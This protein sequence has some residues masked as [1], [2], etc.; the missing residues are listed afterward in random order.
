MVTTPIKISLTERY[1]GAM[2]GLACGD[3]VGCT[4]EFY[5]R[6]KFKP[7]T[8]MTGGGKFRLNPG[9]W[10]DDTSMAICLASSLIECQGHDPVD[11]MNRYSHWYS[12]GQPGP[13]PRP[14]GI[15]KTILQSLFKFRRDGDPYAGDS[16]PRTAGNG[17]LMRLA[18]V[19]LAYF[20]DHEKIHEYAKLST[21]TTHAAEECIQTSAHLAEILFRLLSGRS[22]N[23]IED[24]CVD[25]KGLA[26]LPSSQIHGIGYAPESLRAAVW[27]FLS[28]ESFEQAI[29]AAVNLGDDADT[30]AAICGQMA[31]AYYGKHAIPQKWLEILFMKDE[32]MALADDLY[33]LAYPMGS[34]KFYDRST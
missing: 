9:E 13:K 1:R 2:L 19:P 12:T 23:D 18:P 6:E 25:W 26:L 34:R 7:R 20:P 3:A 27:A 10:T 22:K 30:T 5:P 31:G 28:T 4:V 14:V 33:N 15:G 29:L 16:N 8:D 11:Q 24:V 21:L 17:A 32:I